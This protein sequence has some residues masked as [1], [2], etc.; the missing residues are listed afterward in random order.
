[1]SVETAAGRETYSCP[2]VPIPMKNVDGKVAFISGGSSGIGLGIA[3]ALFDAGMNVVISYRTREHL[4]EAMKYFNGAR[5]RIHAVKLD[6][7]EQ[8]EV[9]AAAA[10]VIKV[11]G[12]VHLLVNNA[13]VYG[14]GP[15]SEA[16]RRDW[17]WMM[18][19]NLVGVFNCV[20]AFLPYMRAHGEGGQI[21][22]TASMWGLYAVD[23][24]AIY[25]ASKAAAI[26]LME[27]LREE[28][29]PLNIGVS[30]YCP[31]SVLS[32]GWN[33]DRNRPPDPTGA[34]NKAS[35]ASSDEVE[36][37]L[38]KL[39]DDGALMDPLEAGRIVLNGIKNNFLH[40]LSHP[41]YEQVIRDRAEALLASVPTNI[42]APAARIA[43]ERA[44]LY[45]PTYPVERDRRRCLARA[46]GQR[47][48][49]TT[50]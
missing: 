1:M 35:T 4:D 34:T 14:M 49:A 16:T 7:T 30:V 5:E 33:A 20:S 41:E 39:R 43:I 13:G 44:T 2:T 45:S 38:K 28:L 12:K 32:R 21:V 18:N 23:K 22:T 48:G 31:G 42:Q 29:Q 19:V 6:V 9:E 40:I 17:D 26:M 25:C 46:A 37:R 10:D 8:A 24:A 47:R 36:A 3:R 50:E 11:F 15:L 27:V